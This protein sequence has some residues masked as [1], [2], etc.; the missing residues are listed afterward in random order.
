MQLSEI[1][2][3]LINVATLVIAIGT[4]ILHETTGFLPE[5]WAYT[6]SLVVAA[7]GAVVHYLAPNET[8][9]PTRVAGRS[10]RLEGEKPYGRH[11][12]PE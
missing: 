10:V 12:L 4:P 3:T 8:S 7:A 1:R 9:D 6:V 2:K 11:A 5:K